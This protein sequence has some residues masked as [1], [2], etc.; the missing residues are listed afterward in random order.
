MIPERI[1]ITE[2][3]DLMY[4]DI[5]SQMAKGVTEMRYDADPNNRELWNDMKTRAV[6]KLKTEGIDVIASMSPDYDV[7]II[8]IGIG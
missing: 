4:R 2:N 6:D 3:A 8:K 5:K 7:I 1:W